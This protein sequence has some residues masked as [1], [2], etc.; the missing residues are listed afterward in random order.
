MTIKVLVYICVILFGSTSW[1]ST[2]SVWLE[3]PLLTDKLPEGWSLPSYF[4]VVVQIASIGP[5]V[6][7]IMLKFSK[8]PFPVPVMILSSLLFCCSCTLLMTAFW[9][10]TI[11]LFGQERSVMLMLLLLGM[12][13]VNATSNV[14]FMPHMA[15]YHGSYIT[16][17]FVGMGLSSLVP[18]SVSMLQGSGVNCVVLNGTSVQT[19]RNLRFG[20]TEYNFIMFGWL[21]L[22][23]SA[24]VYLMH[25]KNAE[26]SSSPPISGSGSHNRQDFNLSNQRTGTCTAL[27]GSHTKFRLRLLLIL[28]AVVSAQMNGIVPSVQ[29]YASLPFS[30]VSFS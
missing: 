1:L 26:V 24:F 18:S 16:A 4:T 17:Y 22:A 9:S 13:L 27:G 21:V 15:T 2:N 10:Q 28:M 11:F 20:V 5:L 7:S 6:Y 12:A 3:L 8:V 19:S 14:L 30:R 25:L 23:T 29:S